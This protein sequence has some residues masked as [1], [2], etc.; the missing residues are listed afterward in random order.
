MLSV[1]R[2]AL[3]AGSPLGVAL[4]RLAQL[5]RR[6]DALDVEGLAARWRSETGCAFGT[7]QEADALLAPPTLDE[8]TAVVRLF[9]AHEER[10][11]HAPAPAG[12]EEAAECEAVRQT[13]QLLRECPLRHATL[14]FL[15][16]ATFKDCSVMLRCLPAAAPD[17]ARAW[18]VEVRLIDLDAKPLAKLGHYAALDRE[19]VDCFAAWRAA[20]E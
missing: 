17:G 10:L 11:G 4:R 20:Q 14:A 3:S 1:L 8:Y 2:P 6:L 5:Q 13:Q 18:R 7:C 15:L 16:S 19:I 9:L 12:D